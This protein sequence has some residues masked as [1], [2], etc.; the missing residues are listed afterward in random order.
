MRTVV[1]SEIPLSTPFEDAAVPEGDEE[2]ACDSDSI[3]FVLGSDCSKFIRGSD[4][5]AIMIVT[6]NNLTYPSSTP[7]L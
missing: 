5:V 3:K 4:R 1:A 6:H 2:D 7:H